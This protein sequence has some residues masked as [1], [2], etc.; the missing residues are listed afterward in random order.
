MNAGATS[1]SGDSTPPSDGPR[2]RLRARAAQAA[3]PSLI[4]DW[5]T[6]EGLS[7]DTFLADVSLSTDTASADDLRLALID[8][9]G[10]IESSPVVARDLARVI[11]R[12]L[13]EEN[14]ALLVKTLLRLQGR[15]VIAEV[16]HL[17]DAIE[18]CHP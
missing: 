2:G 13:E 14:A 9:V 17:T 11:A 1:V 16:A 10:A 4:Y 12:F 7:V 6:I 3:L 5:L 8:V 15:G 18:E